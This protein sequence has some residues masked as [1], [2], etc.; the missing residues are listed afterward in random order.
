MAMNPVRLL[1]VLSRLGLLSPKALS[2]LFLSIRRHGTNLMALLGFAARTYGDRTALVDA[3]SGETLTFRELYG[4]ADRLSDALRETFGLAEGRKVGLWGKNRAA[5]VK[6][7]YAVSAT[8]ADVYLLNAEMGESRWKSLSAGRPFDLLVRDDDLAPL[9]ERTAY[10]G[11]VLSWEEAENLVASSRTAQPRRSKARSSAGKLV[12]LTGG[13]TGAPK[14]AAHKP[15]LFNYLNPFADF[16][17]RL[18]ILKRDTA[19][20][21]TPIY[22]GYGVAVLL[23]FCAAGKKAVVRRGFDA[24]R[25]CRLVREHQ[26]EVVTVVP[27]M[28]RKMLQA[29]EPDDLRSL[30]CIASG[31][32][33]LSPKLAEETRARLGDVL[34]NLYGTSEAGLNLIATPADLAYSAH[35][36]GREIRGLRMR[37]LDERGN[38]AET[39]E[40]GRLCVRNGWSM[41][42]PGA[43]AWIDTGDLACRDEKGYYYLRGRADSLVVSGGE[44]VYPLEVE[45]TLLA[46]PGVEDAAVIGVPDELFGQRLRAFVQPTPGA[47]T[48]EAV[49]AGIGSARGWRASR[50]PGRSSWSTVCLTRLSA[51]LIGR[52]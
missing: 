42:R 4:Q 9:L 27:L 45:Q 19:Y 18:E 8:G 2:R 3:D 38:A 37:I 40:V 49:L 28:L 35:T 51:S 16:L 13:T 43:P 41:S 15:S 23:L 32:A 36:V 14:Q 50:C 12:L 22:H 44:N 30:R 6:T 34:Y 7:I 11:P 46:H 31:G 29:A 39:G 1:D 21:A 52:N 24:E 47:E 5:L 33:E 25:A 26:A 10:D 17:S 48:T 20:I